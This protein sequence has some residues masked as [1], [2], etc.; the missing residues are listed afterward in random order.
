KTR[1]DVRRLAMQILY[2]I[3]MTSNDRRED[4]LSTL[5]QEHDS[6]EI[7]QQA[8]D[9]ALAVWADRE[10][11]DQS[12]TALAEGWPTHRQPPVDR[13]I[14]RLGFYEITSD[15]VAAAIAIDEAVELAKKYCGK[16]SPPFINGVLDKIGRI[17][18]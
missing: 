5:D 12:I 4:I 7:C 10:K 9:L 18:I 13:A 2:Q 15:R 14:L 17:K 1:H 8:V 11:A 3:D 16:K 6:L